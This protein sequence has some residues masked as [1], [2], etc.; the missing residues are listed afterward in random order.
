[1]YVYASYVND[2]DYGQN[3]Y[4]EISSDNIFAL[5]IRK[6]NVPIKFIRLKESRLDYF[7]EWEPGLSILFS[8][9]SKQYTPVRNLPDASFFVTKDGNIFNSFETS[10]RLRFA[11]LEKF[12]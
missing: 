2:F 3:Y 7:K 12:V 9:R 4:D 1:M 6:N 11:Y 8:A 10:V 5:A